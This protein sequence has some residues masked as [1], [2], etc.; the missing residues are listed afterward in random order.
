MAKPSNRPFSDVD[1]QALTVPLKSPVREAR[2]KPPVDNELA[3]SM[4][5]ARA[6]ADARPYPPGVLL[7]DDG[8]GW[9]GTSPHGDRDRWTLQLADAFGTRSG[10]VIDTFV[11]Q[12]QDL[13]GDA[14][15]EVA[16]TFKTNETEL[17]AVIAMVNDVAPENTQE[18]A[19]AAQMVAIHLLQMRMT[20]QALNR[21]GHVFFKDAIAA[22]KLAKTYVEQMGELRRMRGGDNLTRQDIHVHKHFHDHRGGREYGDQ[23]HQPEGEANAESLKP[24]RIPCQRPA[25]PS[26][27]E[28]DGREVPSTCDTGAAHMQ[29]SRKRQGGGRSKGQG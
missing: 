4:G 15:D 13:C 12:L 10:A 21:G 16:Q 25:L 8:D 24:A 26:Q 28:E 23:P 27:G 7:E 22:S 18:A 1:P 14:W 2:E 19:L 3:D 9:R 17:N 29:G 11:F 5:E 6:R 20:K